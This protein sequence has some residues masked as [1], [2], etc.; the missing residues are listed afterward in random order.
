MLVVSLLPA[1]LIS[2]SV[3]TAILAGLVIYRSLVGMKE[4]D[5][6][7]LDPAEAQLEAEQRA[8]LRQLTQLAPFVKGLTIASSGL[9]VLITG[10]WIYRGVAGAAAP[11]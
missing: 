5:Q 10:I 1:L 4:D 9:L 3:I 11:R 7:F 8:I 2:W 6:L